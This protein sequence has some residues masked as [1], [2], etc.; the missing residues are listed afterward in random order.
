M[1]KAF[2]SCV[3]FSNASRYENNRGTGI[4]EQVKVSSIEDTRCMFH[5]LVSR[6]GIKLP[7]VSDLCLYT[8]I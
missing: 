2:I 4:M 7:C 1:G 5:S 3:Y 8:I 6:R